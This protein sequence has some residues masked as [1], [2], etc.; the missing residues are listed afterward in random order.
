MMRAMERRLYRWT[1][2]AE[3]DGPLQEVVPG[4]I[5][6]GYMGR[7]DG[8]GRCEDAALVV[9][10]SDDR[11]LLAVAD[12]MGG[13]ARADDAAAEIVGRLADPPAPAEEDSASRV[14]VLD[15]IEGASTRIR[16]WGVGAATT[17]IVAEVDGDAYRTYHVGDSE[18]VVTGQRGR[19]KWQTIS[20]SPVGY[21]RAS[22]LLGPGDAMVHEDRHLVDSM[23]GLE[24]MRVDLGERRRFSPRDTLVLATDGLFDNLSLDEIV[25][26]IR[27]GPLVAAGS[28][29]VDLA[30]RRMESAR[31]DRPGKPDDLAFILYRPPSP[32]SRKQ[33]P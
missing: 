32:A 17:V 13:G 28:G 10:E 33:N 30:R 26:R 25:A 15:A 21:A 1:H 16:A 8:A 27:S 20:H 11:Y 31:P 19:I 14:R 24:G 3:G 7:P 12:G 6:V 5:V 22:G 18:A 4:R 9:E 29:L 2:R 23:V